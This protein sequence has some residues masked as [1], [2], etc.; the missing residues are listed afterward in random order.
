MERNQVQIAQAIFASFIGK[1]INLETG[2]SDVSLHLLL[3][4]IVSER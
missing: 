2:L 1:G 3:V 4:Y